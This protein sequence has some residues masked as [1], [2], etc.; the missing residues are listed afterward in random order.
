MKLFQPIFLNAPL[1]DA[2]PHLNWA[3][4]LLYPLVAT[5]DIYTWISFFSLLDTNNRRSW[6]GA[7]LFLS[8]Q[9]STGSQRDKHIPSIHCL[10]YIPCH[11]SIKLCLHYF[12]WQRAS[13]HFLIYWQTHSHS[14]ISWNVGLFCDVME[15]PFFMKFARHIM[16]WRPIAII[17]KC[18][19][20]PSFF[21]KFKGFFFP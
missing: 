9:W 17:I 8:F 20:G 5:T 4:Y 18:L 19:G 10:E 7:R 13:H 6:Y 21:L 14:M 12:R 16:I 15:Y 3:Q 11:F 2:S 1:D